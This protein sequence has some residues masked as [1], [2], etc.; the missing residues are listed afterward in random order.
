MVGKGEVN[1]MAFMQ[2]TRNF[3]REWWREIY[4]QMFG[5]WYREHN[6]VPKWMKETKSKKDQ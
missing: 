6:I 2:K 5:D 1:Q 4:W 3:W